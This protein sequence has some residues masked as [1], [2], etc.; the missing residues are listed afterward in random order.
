MQMMALANIPQST[1]GASS[2][3]RGRATD[4]SNHSPDISENHVDIESQGFDHGNV[5]E[6]STPGVPLETTI[7]ASDSSVTWEAA[8]CPKPSRY[9][10]QTRQVY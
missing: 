3:Q 2:R 6:T 7:G 8:G 4:A 9:A 5:S 10:F 1:E